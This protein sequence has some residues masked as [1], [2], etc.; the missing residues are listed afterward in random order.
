MPVVYAAV[1]IGF[2]VLALVCLATFGFVLGPVL[3]LTA[4]GLF[5]LG[6]RAL[7]RRVSDDP[8]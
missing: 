2:V 7:H 8:R 6:A 3:W 1:F 5:H 4:Y